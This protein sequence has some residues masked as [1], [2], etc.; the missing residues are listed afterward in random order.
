MHPKAALI[1][2]FSIALLLVGSACGNNIP[3]DDDD[4][5]PDDDDPAGDD[6]DSAGDD[7]DSSD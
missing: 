2:L 5:I 1:A 3:D 4:F 6:D 7:D